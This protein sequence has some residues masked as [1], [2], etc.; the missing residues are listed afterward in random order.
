MPKR[1]DKSLDQNST[2]AELLAFRKQID[3]MDERIIQLLKERAQIVEKVGEYKKSNGQ[4]GCFIRPGREADMLRHIWKA[5]GK[6]KFSPV[7][8]ASIWR[9]IIGASTNIENRLRISVCAPD[10]DETLYWLA[11]EYFGPFCN[12]IRHPNAKRVVGDLLDGKAEVGLLP[13]VQHEQHGDWWITLAEQGKNAPK[14]FAHVPFVTDARESRRRSSYAI[15]KISPESTDEDITLIAVDTADISLNRLITAFTTAG[16]KAARIQ[17]SDV[18]PGGRVY[19]LLRVEGFV[20]DDDPRL[21][22]VFA[23]LKE[24]V[25]DWHILGA[26][27][28]P[29]LTREP[30]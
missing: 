19:H 11:R 22:Q 14:L 16:L 13:P 10:E 6:E 27:A 15:A 23:P 5:F 30:C 24:S 21:K 25:A 9:L 8:A 12:V 26:Y 7:A 18:L 28:T 4:K 1:T 29:I 2:P 20:S 3:H 17:F